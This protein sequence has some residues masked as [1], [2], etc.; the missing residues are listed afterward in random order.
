[1]S[2]AEAKK[3]LRVEFDDDDELIGNLIT[4]SREYAEGFLNRKLV[5]AEEGA[6]PPVV[7]Q[8]WKQAML[9][10][11]GHWYEHRESVNAGGLTEIP[12]GVDMLL[13]QDRNVVFA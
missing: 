6:E 7:P 3:H 2:L 13:W 5:A 4:A 10:L 9:L 8:K 1:L 12:M 11:I